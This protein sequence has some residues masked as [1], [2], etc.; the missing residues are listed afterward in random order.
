MAPGY[1][2]AVARWAV[3][4]LESP[5][6][7]LTHNAPQEGYHARTVWPFEQAGI[8]AAAQA[9]G[10]PDVAAVAARVAA[11][12][13][14]SEGAPEY[15]RVPVQGAPEAAGCSRQLWTAGA[16]AYFDAQRSTMGELASLPLPDGLRGVPPALAESVYRCSG[17][18]AV[19]RCPSAPGTVLPCAALNDDYCD[20]PHGEDEPGTAACAH[21]GRSGVGFWCP[22][23]GESLGGDVGPGLPREEGGGTFAERAEKRALAEGLV[24]LDTRALAQ[25]AASVPTPGRGGGGGGRTAFTS[26]WDSA[27]GKAALAQHTMPSAAVAEA[28]RVGLWLPSSR[29]GDG[30]CDCAGCEDERGGA[31]AVGP[32]P[33][34]LTAPAPAL[35]VA[36]VAQGAD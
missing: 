6:G 1:T 27:Q 19:W 23:E 26:W 10:L 3:Q 15:Y 13:A 12:L 14:Q 22:R 21:V 32:G 11:L 2:A 25:A 4:A 7:F 5:A 8:H 34:F 30:V 18:G 29:V 9:H 35:M 31:A 20:C 28:A 36:G 24:R 33:T 17:E 16:R